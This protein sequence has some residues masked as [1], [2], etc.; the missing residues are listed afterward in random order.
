[1]GLMG[2][3]AKVAIG[4]A[5]ARGVDKLAGGQGL[6]GLLGGGAQIKGK[7][8]LSS[9]QAQIGQSMSGQMPTGSNPMQAMMDKM[10]E[11]GLDLSTLTGGAGG[12]AG[13]PMA[14]IMDK[15]KESGLDLSALMGGGT[16]APGEKGPLLS[17]VPSGGS[18]LAGMLAAAGGMAA[19]QGKGLGGLMDQFGTADTSQEADKSAALMLRAMIQSAKADGGIDKDE[20]AKILE[21]VG[22]D[23]T[24]D[25]IAF[26]KAQLAAPIDV[27][28]LAKDTPEAQKVQV[29]SASLMTIR[30]DTQA[31]AEYLD[32]LATAMGLDE[33]AVNMLHMQMGLQPLYN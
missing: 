11:S 27:K 10:K 22:D 24:P 28:G 12:A 31:E 20:K 19:M 14:A 18:G 30:V 16:P 5:A 8:P 33:T 4:Y 23:A 32:A 26:V 13:N 3:L 29:Y 25:D 9:T 1:M 17:S 7:N 2:T 21:T 6:G 15:M